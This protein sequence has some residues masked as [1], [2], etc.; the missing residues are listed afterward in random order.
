MCASLTIVHNT[1][2][3]SL[4]SPQPTVWSEPMLSRMQSTSFY[5]RRS[6]FLYLLP[7][8]LRMSDSE[9]TNLLCACV[10]KIFAPVHKQSRSRC[11]NTSIRFLLFQQRIFCLSKNSPVDGGS[12]LMQHF[13]L[14][15]M[16]SF[17]N[18]IGTIHKGDVFDRL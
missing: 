4:A 7:V 9:S 15:Q 2:P 13:L 10:R 5:A 14:A 16:G 11:E 12:L 6:L 3:P 18:R 8:R 1:R 17:R